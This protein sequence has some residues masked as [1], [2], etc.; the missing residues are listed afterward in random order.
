MA[1][2]SFFSIITASFNYDR[3]LAKTLESARCQSLDA[4]EHIVIDGGSTDGT[5]EILKR[6]ESQYPLQWRSEPDRGIADALNKGIALARGTYIV[7][8][9][10]DDILLDRHVLSRVYELARS[11]SHDIFS[12]PVLRNDPIK[13]IVS[14]KPFKIRW[15]YHFK[16]IIPHQGAFVHRRVFEKIGFFRKEVSIAMDY[17]FFYRALQS[18][19]SI[20]Y[21]HVPVAMMQGCGISSNL[22]WLPKRLDEEFMVQQLNEHTAFWRIAQRIFRTLYLPYKRL[23]V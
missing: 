12:F 23:T 5:L 8:I 2:A 16:T 18:G 10:A 21:A 9:Q 13:G 17:D 3:T 19:A 11:E 4:R 20:R 15:W 7:V 1:S 22:E 6:Y 14:Y